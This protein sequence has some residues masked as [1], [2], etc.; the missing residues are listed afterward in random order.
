MSRFIWN[1]TSFK[2]TRCSVTGYVGRRK[3]FFSLLI[4]NIWCQKYNSPFQRRGTAADRWQKYKEKRKV[5]HAVKG[6]TTNHLP[7]TENTSEL[8]PA[9]RASTHYSPS[10]R[11]GLMTSWHG[12]RRRAWRPADRPGPEADLH[13]PPFLRPALSSKPAKML[14]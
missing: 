2:L 6:K 1:E 3:M 4:R 12:D 7:P 9:E 11:R 8:L 5:S 10:C 14:P 13:P